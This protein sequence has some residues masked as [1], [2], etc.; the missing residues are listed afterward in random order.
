MK[1][2]KRHIVLATLVVALSAAVYINWQF[3]G[4]KTLSVSTTGKE[5]GAAT[6]V[7]SNITTADEVSAKLT[8][9]NQ[10]L[11]DEQK[12]YFAIS[13]QEREDAQDS[14]VD[15]AKET[16]EL[17]ESSEEAREEAVEQLSSIEN[18]ILNQNR[19]ETI[20][21]AKGFS[22]CICT[23]TDTSCT[24]VV[25]Q[26]DMN[27]TKALVIKDCVQDVSK[28]PFEEITIIEI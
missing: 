12:E 1:F 27:E 17:A 6:Y 5:L 10:S 15:L 2:R 28:L 19:I 24:V 14:A 23:L 13:R 26:N 25:P 9:K 7:N 3:A 8:K 20:V 11:T 16:L 18:M 22:D 21:T 4:D